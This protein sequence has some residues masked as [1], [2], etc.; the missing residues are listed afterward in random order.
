MRKPAVPANMLRFHDRLQVRGNALVSYHSRKGKV[1]S[2]AK[3]LLTAKMSEVRKGAYSGKLTAG[4]RR[5]LVKALEMFG[6]V[7][8]ERK[9]INP[10]SGKLM[11]FHSSFVTLTLPV[12]VTIAQEKQVVG[13]LL[14]G[15]L[16]AVV[17]GYEVRNYVWRC[18]RTKEGR[19]HIHAIIDQPI[20][21]KTVQNIWNKQLRK[22]GML[23][24]YAKN[25]GHYNAPSTHIKGVKSRATTCKYMSKYMSKEE[26]QSKP[27]GCKIWDC[28]KKLKAMSWPVIEGCRELVAEVYNEWQ[29]C[30]DSYYGGENWVYLALKE[31]RSGSYIMSW[32]KRVISEWTE[33]MRECREWV[34]N[35]RMDKRT[36]APQLKRIEIKPKMTQ[37]QLNIC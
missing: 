37:L 24:N 13:K 34:D 28:N 4:S 20:H 6:L 18:E 23:D 25:E 36:D 12:E 27:L 3:R 16:Q 22:A 11:S 26:K 5:K 8:E 19:L 29:A 15:W 30:V 2:D 17:R 1:T 21:M 33:C 9:L 31:L 10:F 7:V 35:S 32:H 14:K